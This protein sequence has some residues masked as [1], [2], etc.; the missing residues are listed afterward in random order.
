VKTAWLRSLLLPIALGAT[1]ASCSRP[2]PASMPLSPEA[3]R[4]EE[5]RPESSRVDGPESPPPENPPEQIIEIDPD[6][7]P[8]DPGNVGHGVPRSSTG[9]ASAAGRDPEGGACTVG[10]GPAIDCSVLGKGT[11]SCLGARLAERACETWAPSLDPRVGAAWL[12]CMASA[13]SDA[14]ARCDTATITNCG[15]HAIEGA[16]VDGTYR[17]KCRDIA[18]E[19]AEMTPVL[20]EAVCERAVSAFRPEQRPAIAECL[21][22]GCQTGAFGSCIP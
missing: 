7:D 6:D 3:A 15:L 10:R 1:A 20:T 17:R 4:A 12:D 13:K 9:A 5:R 2:S 19:C 16:C 14:A 21:L 22:H 8:D 18:T 11:S